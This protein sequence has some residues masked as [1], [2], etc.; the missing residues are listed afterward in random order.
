[1]VKAKYQLRVIML[2]LVLIISSVSI[3]AYARDV[4]GDDASQDVFKLET[5]TVTSEKRE[6][7]V[8]TIPSSLTVVGD[9]QID[10]F[11]IKS[12]LDL[13]SVTPNLYFLN[14]GD[15]MLAMVSMRGLFQFYDIASPVGIYVDDV[16]YTGLDINFYDIERIEVL[17]GP[18]GTLY[19][20]NSEAGVINVIT[21]KP[22]SVWEGSV[23]LEA[24]ALTAMG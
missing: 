11:E 5:I 15:P 4:Q 21:K 2:S 17:R 19:G 13:A 6:K 18:Q 24:A 12:T 9:T 7:D 16:P 22:S 3:S 1:M 20:R 23:G 10:D 8:Q 14:V